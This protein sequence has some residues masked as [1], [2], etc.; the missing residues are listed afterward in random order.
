MTDANYEINIKYGWI[1]FSQ[2]FKP[3]KL[4]WFEEV[5]NYRLDIAN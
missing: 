5:N 4:G 2:G 1:F 3:W